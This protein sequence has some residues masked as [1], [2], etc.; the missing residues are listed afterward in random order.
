VVYVRDV[1]TWFKFG[2]DRFRGLASAEGQIYHSHI[3]FDGSPCN[4]ISPEVEAV[5]ASCCSR[6]LRRLYILWSGSLGVLLTAKRQ[7]V[8]IL[9]MSANAPSNT[10]T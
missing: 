9:S 7:H 3:D 6:R 10:M 2:D 5:I 8:L 4:N 1:I